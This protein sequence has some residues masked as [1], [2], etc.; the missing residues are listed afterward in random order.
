MVF[1]SVRLPLSILYCVRLNACSR[2][3]G[4]AKIYIHNY[5]H[6][7]I[8]TGRLARKSG[9][10]G[11]FKLWSCSAARRE[12]L[13]ATIHMYAYIYIYIYTCG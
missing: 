9:L 4:R 11:G 6:I 10:D 8:R 13:R 1:G 12:W 3:R 2:V 5:V 7:H